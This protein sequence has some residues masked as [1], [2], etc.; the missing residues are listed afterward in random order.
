MNTRVAAAS[1][2]P[3]NV[4]LTVMG[5]AA[6]A[7]PIVI[8]TMIPLQIRAQPATV[9]GTQGSP[10][11][12]FEVASIKPNNNCVGDNQDEQFS[13]GRV[14][15]TCIRLSNLIK[16]AYG[17]FANGPNSKATRLRLYGL[18]EW[19]NSSRYDITAKT[20][21]EAPIDQMFGPMLQ[22]L[23]EDR[24]Q[25][26]VHRETR[27]LPVYVMTVAKRGLKIQPTKEGSCVPV[28]LNHAYQ[29]TPKWCGRMTGRANS[30]GIIDHAYGMTI[31]EIASRFLT[32]RL[33]RLVV[34]KTEITGLFDAHLEFSRTAPI[35]PGQVGEPSDTAP[36]IFTAVQEQ[37]GLKLEPGQGPVEVLVIDH[38][39]KPSEN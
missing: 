13:A 20:A 1:N 21:G 8:G 7:L 14:G 24:F 37:L 36:S 25:L 9:S 6:Q 28:D 39:E 11:P 30:I 10:R 22:V 34:D 29:P 33:D 2:S 16:A 19:A 32:N 12:A 15:V 17:T 5:I 31:A 35:A 26:K 23:L 27:Q 38:V 18:P 3:R 4:F